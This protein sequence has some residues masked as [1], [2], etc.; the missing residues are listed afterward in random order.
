[1]SSP[2]SNEAKM[3]LKLLDDG[4]WHTL[5][6]I[7]SRLAATVPP[8]KALR[9]YDTREAQ[10]EEKYGPRKT[11]ELPDEMK[12]ASGQRTLAN[13]VINSLK[14]RYVDIVETVNGRMVRKR[15]QPAPDEPMEVDAAELEDMLADTDDSKSDT[16]EVT[17]AAPQRAENP[18]EPT[19]RRAAHNCPRCGMWVVNTVQHDLFHAE[20]DNTAAAA[21]QFPV[22]K[23]APEPAEPVSS[24]DD[25]EMA[26]FSEVQIREIV[27]SEVAR[28][29]GK[30]EA[31][32][33]VTEADN[34]KIRKLV[35]AE[36]ETALDGFQHGME[37][38]LN[39]RLYDLEMALTKPA[40]GRLPFRGGARSR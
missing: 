34:D 10:R 9:R 39:Q 31:T 36:V 35:R 6:S 7:T 1:M 15:A 18:K 29:L 11:P 30:F 32:M 38:F 22:P 4:Q 17:N 12:I 26:L 5:E 14:K 28:A 13:V 23:P 3:L 19:A 33:V 2:M 21:R 24:T 8:G 27:Y 40:R 16:Q 37:T 25:S 20:Q